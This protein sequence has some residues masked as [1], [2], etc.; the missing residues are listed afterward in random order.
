MKHLF[1]KLLA[2][3]VMPALIITALFLH[4]I[5]KSFGADS[6][7]LERPCSVIVFDSQN[8]KIGEYKGTSSELDPFK[9]AEQFGANPLP[10]DKIV[11]TPDLS[12]GFGSIISLYRA[13]EYTVIDGKKSI[14]LRSWQ[15]TVGELLTEGNIELG[16]DDKINF[17]TDTE[18]FHDMKITIIR[19]AITNIKESQ[20]ID[21]NI[22]KKDDPTMDKGKTKIQTQG[23][24]GTKVLTYRVQREDGVEVSRK[25]INTEITVE[26]VTQVVLIGTRPVITVRCNYNDTVI[27]A[28]LKYSIDPNTVCNLMMK[29]SNGHYN[30][31]GGNNQYFGLFQ[32][33]ES[34]WAQASKSAGYGGASCFDPTAQIYTTAWALTH[35]FSGRW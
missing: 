31:V 8:N 21:F 27:A 34:F 4:N 7:D 5:S 9:I 25:L 1:R 26:P 6:N 14:I 24:K 15:K 17:S 28:S 20:P 13:P 19:V 16:D 33:T 22:V 11:V 35:G 2:G 29:E 23:Q 32:Y 10:E 3:A 30:S 12:Q 18:L